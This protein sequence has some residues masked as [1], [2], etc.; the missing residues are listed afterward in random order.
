MRVVGA[1]LILSALVSV[2]HAEEAAAIRAV[3]SDSNTPPY[4]IFNAE[5]GLEAGISKDILDELAKA[6]QKPIHYLN[7]PVNGWV[8]HAVLLILNLNRC[9]RWEM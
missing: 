5:N 1:W 6:L 4:A 2:T 9:L 8:P 3:V 7:L